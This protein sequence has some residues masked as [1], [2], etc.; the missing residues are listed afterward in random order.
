MRDEGPR[1]GSPAPATATMAGMAGKP[2]RRGFQLRASTWL[3]LTGT[4]A[5]AWYYLGAAALLGVP[6][7]AL[8]ALVAWYVRQPATVALFVTIGHSILVLAIK[9][10]A[11]REEGVEGWA[12]GMT[13]IFLDAPLI[14]LYTWIAQILERAGYNDVAIFACPLLIGGPFYGWLAYWIGKH[15]IQRQRTQYG[16]L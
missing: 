2:Q 5:A 13:M 15:S 3:V 10:W 12:R 7:L 11:L 1:T 6:L 14:P 8:V 9:N 16:T 4:V